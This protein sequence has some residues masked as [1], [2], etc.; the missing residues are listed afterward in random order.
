MAK[1]K[2]EDT[3]ESEVQAEEAQEETQAEEQT[4]L[5]DEQVAEQV[6]QLTNE[7]SEV[8]EDQVEEQSEET[9]E[10]TEEVQAE[11]PIIDEEMV[12]DNPVLRSYIGKPVTNLA[13]AYQRIVSQ[14]HNNSKELAELKRQIAESSLQNTDDIPDMVEKPE[15]F[16]KWKEDFAKANQEIGA[17]QKQEPQVDLMAELAKRLP[18]GTDVNKTV[19]G[20][21]NDNAE[22]LFDELG[23]FR[24]E[25]ES[26]YQKNPE[27]LYK[28]VVKFQQNYEKENE[29]EAVTRKA[30]H[31]KLKSDFKKARDSKKEAPGTQVNTISKDVKLTPEEEMLVEIQELVQEE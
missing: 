12:K 9:E 11:I 28:E 19:Q 2:S 18:Q 20:F 13:P 1:K 14:Y 5:S 22:R 30:G 6:S 16:K 4:E 29:D 24:P 26:L 31:K 8:S 23:Q 27:V 15:E 10:Q 7:E 25:M 3:Q 17:G 21:L